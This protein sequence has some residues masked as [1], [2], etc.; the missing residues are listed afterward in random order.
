MLPIQPL[1]YLLFFYY[2]YINEKC[3]LKKKKNFWED[4]YSVVF[5][6]IISMEELY[7]VPR[8]RCVVGM[9]ESHTFRKIIRWGRN[10]FVGFFHGY[11]LSSFKNHFVRDL[12]VW[13]GSSCTLSFRLC[14]A[15]SDK[16]TMDVVAPFSSLESP[17]FLWK[18]R[19]ERLEP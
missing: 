15:L 11:H 5:F 14:H 18:V 12:L 3:F 19:W 13:T 9:G 17:L 10:L 2:Y 6:F 7:V 16:E 8:V 4:H 1:C